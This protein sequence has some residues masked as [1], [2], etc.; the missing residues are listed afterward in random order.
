MLDNVID[1]RSKLVLICHFMGAPVPAPTQ[2]DSSNENDPLPMNSTTPIK[3]EKEKSRRRGFKGKTVPD[4]G[5]VLEAD[6]TNRHLQLLDPRNLQL[7][8]TS[9]STKIRQINTDT[10]GLFPT[11]TIDCQCLTCSSQLVSSVRCATVTVQAR[12]CSIQGFD[13]LA[14]DEFRNGCLYVQTL[15]SRLRHTS[16]AQDLKNPK[17][18][19]DSSRK[20][21]DGDHSGTCSMKTENDELWCQWKVFWFSDTLLS[22]MELMLEL[23]V[24][25][26]DADQPEKANEAIQELE[27]ILFEFFVGPVEHRTMKLVATMKLVRLRLELI[28]SMPASSS[29]TVKEDI[30]DSDII[31]EVSNASVPKTPAH[32]LRRPRP[33]VA[34]GPKRNRFD[35]VGLSDSPIT[36]T[37]I[38]PFF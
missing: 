33:N 23:V 19:K 32:A 20:L 4:V 1:C 35:Q 26:T 27:S 10:D 22:M 28:R 15:C 31:L 2:P 14:E 30:V 7:Q 36:I 18:S 3:P 37:V 34:M 6:A 38:I 5:V 11:H 16:T 24:H 12:L 17:K 13:Q 29:T 9:P 21:F 25:R 8:G